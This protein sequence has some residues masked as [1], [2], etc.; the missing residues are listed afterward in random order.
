MANLRSQINPRTDQ[1]PAHQIVDLVGVENRDVRRQSGFE[2][3]A[4]EPQL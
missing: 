3:T 2:I 4:V 1:P